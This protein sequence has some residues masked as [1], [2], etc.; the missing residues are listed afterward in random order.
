MGVIAKSNREIT[1]YYN[2]ESQIGKQGYAYAQSSDK[3]VRGI[4]ISKTKVTGTQWSELAENLH[5]P[6]KD[7]IDTEHPDFIKEYGEEPVSMEDHDW[8]KIIQHS[9]KL[10]TY[11]IVI[12]G[13]EYHQLTS[14]ADLKKYL[15]PNSAGIEDTEKLQ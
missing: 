7:L 15:E 1:L 4:D 5:I 2:S 13:E 14:G 10:V 3:K 12:M 9:P 8:L 6:I 11:P